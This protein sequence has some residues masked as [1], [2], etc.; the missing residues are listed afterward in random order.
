MELINPG[1]DLRRWY[2][3][4]R[5]HLGPCQHATVKRRSDLESNIGLHLSARLPVWSIS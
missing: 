5:T 1:F 4:G 3:R 2:M